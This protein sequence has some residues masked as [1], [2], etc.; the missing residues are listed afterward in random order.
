MAR[1]RTETV[2]KAIAPADQPERFRIGEIGYSGLSIFD[3]VTNEE[4]KRELNFPYNIK[5][6]REMSYHT[7]VNACLQ[8]YENLISKVTWR[9]VPPKDASEEE[10]K[11]A[12]FVE[13]CLHDMDVPFRQVIKDALSSNV[14]GFAVLEKVYRRRNT[15]SGSMYSDNKIALKKIALRSQETIEKFIFDDSG[16]EILGVKQNLTNVQNGKLY[17]NRSKQELEVVL[18]RSKVMLVTTGRN[19]NDPYG[20]SP[21]R[22]VYLAWRYLTVIQEIEA[23]GVARDL[24]GMP[25]LKIPAQYMSDDASPDQKTI[26]EN[27]KNIIR[28]IQN[29]SQSGV[30]LP[31]Q[32]DPETRQPLFDLTLLSTEGGKKNFDTGKVKE[33]YQNMIY[34]GLFADVLILGQGG[35]GSFALGQIKNS[36]TGS[37]VESMLDNIVEVFNRDVIRQLYELNGWN[38]ARSS[39][40]DY[41]GLHAV[42]LETLSKYWQRVT[43][44]GLVEK[45]RPVL[46]AVRPAAGLDPIAEDVEPREEY[47]SDATSRS[48]DGMEKGSGNGTSDKVAGEDNSSDN[49]DNKA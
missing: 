13:Q 14:Y 30:I 6:Y 49:L 1:K 26:Y 29:N 34:T 10:K 20:K 46:N 27:F 41:E 24:Q 4:I 17:G 9:I 18:P 33:Y 15:N 44:V 31:S 40:L 28:N 39:T 47:L 35:V 19:R 12:E 11:Q 7:S 32:T 45:D 8:L 38:V 37:A 43:S 5:T 42:D 2:E 16:N 23:A 36:L 21:L 48:G 25:V 3:G 22:D